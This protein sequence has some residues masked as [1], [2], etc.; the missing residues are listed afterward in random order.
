M[1]IDDDAAALRLA[2]G[3]FVRR[4]RQDTA[5]LPSSQLAALGRLERDGPRTVAELAG[6]ERVSH[7]SMTRLVR[8]LADQGL[9]EPAPAPAGDRRRRPWRASAQGR[10]VLGEQRARRA[11]WLAAAMRRELTAAERRTLA[12]ATALLERLASAE[13]SG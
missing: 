1:S 8:A 10:A 5:T 13:P 6:A 11:D 4:V 9:A 2:V 7:Q 12:D 3:R